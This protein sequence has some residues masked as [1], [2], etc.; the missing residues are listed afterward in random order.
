MNTNGGIHV[1]RPQ[2]KKFL[3]LL[4]N[5]EASSLVRAFVYSEEYKKRAIHADF[6]PLYSRDLERSIKYFKSFYPVQFLLRAL[7][8][9]YIVYRKNL[10]LKRIAGYN[11]IIVIKY[12]D[13]GLMK[14]VKLLSKALLVYD[15]DDAVWLNSF[16]G[17]DEFSKIISEADCIT[18][19]NHYL[20]NY[21]SVYNKNSF[22]LNGPCQIEKFIEIKSTVNS[23]HSDKTVTLGWV[24]SPGTLFYLY[25]IYDALEIIGGRYPDVILKLVGTG[26]DR[27]LIPQFEKIKVVTVPAY[28]QNEMIEQVYSFD[29]G[30]YPLFYNELSLGRGS[31]KATIYMAGGIPAVCSAF[32]ENVNIIQDGING[33]LASDNDEWVEKLSVLIEDPVLRMEI[34]KKG[35]EYAL[36]NYSVASCLTQFLEIVEKQAEDNK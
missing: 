27:R 15:F 10:L 8:R 21:S 25:K 18:S 14:Q 1:P 26:S 6:F 4:F 2:N 20:S 24:G 13:T 31:L 7:N 33:S 34:G 16:F 11:V 36:A 35:F 9:L 22:V 29:I 5:G 23:S 3:Y 17:E 30:L 19:D 12:I 28:D 32:G